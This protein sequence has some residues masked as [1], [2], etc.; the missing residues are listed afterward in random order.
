[1]LIF[2]ETYRAFWTGLNWL[3]MI[4]IRTIVEEYANRKLGDIGGFAKK[5]KIL[6]E[7]GYINNTQ[8]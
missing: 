1:M 4:G 6:H 5:I 2:W 3:A 8:F 7:K